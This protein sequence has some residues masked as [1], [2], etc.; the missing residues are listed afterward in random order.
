MSTL[1]ATNLQHKDSSDPNV[2]LYA[3]GSTSIRSLQNFGTLASS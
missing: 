2:V 1:K 3:D